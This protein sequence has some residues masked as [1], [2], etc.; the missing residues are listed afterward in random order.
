[1]W[2]LK[3]AIM[4]VDEFNTLP[5]LKR[6]VQVFGYLY[7][8]FIGLPLTTCIGLPLPRVAKSALD[9]GLLHLWQ[10]GE[11]ALNKEGKEIKVG[12]IKKNVEE[13]KTR[14]HKRERKKVHSEIRNNKRESS[15][16]SHYAICSEV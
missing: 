6:Q 10:S 5:C 16:Q 7:C 13:K 8:Y 11:R 2:M 15:I 12:E 1:M 3:N 14:K 4:K 9:G